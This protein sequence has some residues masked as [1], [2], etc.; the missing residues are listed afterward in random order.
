MASLEAVLCGAI[1]IVQNTCN[2]YDGFEYFSMKDPLKSIIYSEEIAERNF[3]KAQQMLTVP[4]E[5]MNNH[6]LEILNNK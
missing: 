3:H 4:R 6:L 2:L 5:I 1:P